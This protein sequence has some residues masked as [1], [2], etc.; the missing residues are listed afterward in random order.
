MIKLILKNKIYTLSL[1]A[2]TII[3]IGICIF[4]SFQNISS[5]FIMY[6]MARWSYYAAFYLS[7]L[8][9]FL[10]TKAYTAH[11]N[12]VIDCAKK[13]HFAWQK[14]VIKIVLLYFVLY[15]VVLSVLVTGCSIHDLSFSYFITVLIRMYS[16]NIVLPQFILIVIAFLASLIFEYGEIR[17]Y[18]FMIV[19]YVLFSP[20]LERIVWVE[21]PEGIPIDQ[22]VNNIK[23]CFAI[24]YQN[25]TWAPDLQYGLQTESVR[26][27][28]QLFWI[29]LF[30]GILVL[31]LKG[32]KRYF[33]AGICFIA[34]FVCFICSFQ[35][36]SLYRFREDWDGIFVDEQYYSDK[37]TTDQLTV[38]QDLYHSTDEIYHENS[39]LPYKI[40]EYDLNIDIRNRLHVSGDLN[41]SIEEA[42]DHIEL[43][44]YH[45]YEIKNIKVNNNQADYNVDGDFVSIA[46]EPEVGVI[47]VTIEYE[48]IS[49]KF[50]TN[51]QAIMLP[52]YFPWYPMAGQ[53]IVYVTYDSYMGGSGYNPYNRVDTASIHLNI[54]AS[55]NYVTNLTRMENGVYSGTSDSIT[56]VGGNICETDD[57]RIKDY[58]PF[59]KNG[60]TADE[61]ISSLNRTW[62]LAIDNLSNIFGISVDKLSQKEII[63][64]SEDIGRNFAN[65]CFVEFDD[66]ILTTEAYLNSSG[67]LNYRLYGCQKK[68]YYAVWL[69]ASFTYDEE[70]TSSD[71]CISNMLQR[72]YYESSAMGNYNEDSL[73]EYK[74]EVFPIESIVQQYGNE[75][76]LKELVN[77][78]LHDESCTNDEEFLA[79]MSTV[80]D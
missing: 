33:T 58:L 19:F 49:N 57:E 47:D 38:D 79:K 5:Y 6:V 18:S 76:F 7:L 36:T 34:A 35:T 30:A 24:F 51:D 27:Y 25:A 65:N 63:L 42:I 2:Y 12:L 8:T 21:K 60:I 74:K 78:L 3:T 59:E 9:F 71:L 23:W 43:T 22:I 64:V 14:S 17:A 28:L 41:I 10:C 39:D 4:L 32:K 15:H 52:G 29:I 62:D 13:A 48:G 26:L 55:C 16:L 37:L 70:R 73:Q 40:D 61:Y 20:F 67:Y 75:K 53:K 31:I 44:L 11:S 45:G 69:G 1:I 80:K 66:Y 77:Y 50:Y 46:I 72:V 54:S 68:S 56:I